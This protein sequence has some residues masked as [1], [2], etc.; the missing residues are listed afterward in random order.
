MEDH[1]ALGR[2]MEDDAG[3]SGI[4]EETEDA[5]AWQIVITSNNIS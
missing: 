1:K 2:E 4:S 3:A 5:G